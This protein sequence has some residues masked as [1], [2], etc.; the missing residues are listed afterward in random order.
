MP[1]EKDF[2]NQSPSNNALLSLIEKTYAV[3][4]HPEKLT[5][6]LATLD[7]FLET[8]N[9]KKP[10]RRSD[11]AR[12][13]SEHINQAFEIVDRMDRSSDPEYIL[14]A[15]PYP[16]WFCNGVGDIPYIN[17]DAINYFGKANNISSLPISIDNQ[18]QLLDTIEDVF[19]NNNSHLINVILTDL[20]NDRLPLIVTPWGNSVDDND[21]ILVRI[22]VTSWPTN[23]SAAIQSSYK[24]TT[25]EIE[26]LEALVKGYSPSEIASLRN[27]KTETIR[28]QLKS[29]FRKT[30]TSS[31]IDVVR[32]ITGIVGASNFYNKPK[33]VQHDGLHI[34]KTASTIREKIQIKLPDDRMMTVYKC[35]ALKGDPFVYIHGHLD[36]ALLSDEIAQ[37]FAEYNLLAICPV[38]PGF[39]DSSSCPPPF[40]DVDNALKTTCHDLK[41]MSESLGIDQAVYVGLYAGGVYAY[42]MAAIQEQSVSEL[43]LIT[44]G[45]IP[46][47]SEELQ[48][49]S[50]NF[51]ILMKAVRSSPQMMRFI[52]K[53]Y[54]YLVRTNKFAVLWDAYFKNTN[55]KKDPDNILLQS[56]DFR[57]SY[58]ESIRFVLAQGSNALFNDWLVFSCP[59]NPVDTVLDK[60]I[61]LLRGNHDIYI[62]QEM[63]EHRRLLYPNVSIKSI[64]DAGVFV[65]FQKPRE[66]IKEIAAAVRKNALNQ[67]ESK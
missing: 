10:N 59:Y 44:C 55:P 31:Q 17:H 14:E 2:S 24:L 47:T 60:P 15:M 51:R 39:G 40:P 36:N 13:V 28:V 32:L 30:G 19:N 12:E 33:K 42:A 6:F 26:V 61:L 1:K 45:T 18:Q 64:E 49:F 50:P 52:I 56:N 38:R 7:A 41:L 27:A 20:S 16:A 9:S 66:V 21:L 29:I 4:I 5:E 62:T 3:A 35:G 58:M 48:T 43:I 25:A 53:I 65:L 34:S 67:N 11:D 57:R 54:G 37:I 23:V 46:I 8:K 22:V 63:I